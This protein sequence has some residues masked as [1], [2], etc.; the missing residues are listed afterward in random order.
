MTERREDT[1]TRVHFEPDHHAAAARRYF[2]EASKAASTLGAVPATVTA[3]QWFADKPFELE[4][5]HLAVLDGQP[6]VMLPRGRRP[7]AEG[8]WVVVSA[9]EVS[10]MSD[11][12]FRRTFE[13]ST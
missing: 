13:V 2:S 12:S 11:E 3:A 5:A 7:L 10:V 4:G 1:A 8:E 6:C 9:G